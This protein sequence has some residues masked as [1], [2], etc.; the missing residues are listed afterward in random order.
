MLAEMFMLRLEAATHVTGEP[1]Q[2]S[3][4]VPFDKVTFGGF[5]AQRAKPAPAR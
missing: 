3:R 4:Y 5:K 1:K 2:T